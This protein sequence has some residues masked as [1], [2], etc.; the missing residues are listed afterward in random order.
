[1]ERR[2]WMRAM[3][4]LA[5]GALLGPIAGW[6]ADKPVIKPPAILAHVDFSDCY[7]IGSTVRYR[8]GTVTVSLSID[9]DGKITDVEFPP[10]TPRW[11]ANAAQCAVDRHEFTPGT[12]DG[13]PVESQATLPIN[14]RVRGSSGQPAPAIVRP[15]L[16]S[17]EPELEAAYRDCYPADL[18]GERVILYRSTVGVDGRARGTKA[19]PGS[20]DP[21]LDKAG[22]CVL[23]KLRFIPALRGSQAVK[24]TITW[25]LL[26]RPAQS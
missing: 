21:R 9:A 3:T 6:S 8:E 15:A 18:T 19:V 7:P 16:R 11:L 24:V 23:G 12:L 25:S 5:A 22:A 1:M 26:V 17:D 13:V 20:G 2:L 10:G 14:F 4:V